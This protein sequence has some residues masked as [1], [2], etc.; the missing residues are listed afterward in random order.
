MKDGD[1]K[2]T[3]MK[4][5]MPLDVYP[6]KGT[7]VIVDEIQN[8]MNSG[9]LR[10]KALRA[11]LR[12][13]RLK[14]G[15]TWGATGT[16]MHNQPMELCNVLKVLDLFNEAFGNWAKFIQL[17]GGAQEEKNFGGRPKKIWNWNVPTKPRNDAEKRKLDEIV[18]CMRRVS[19][20]REMDKVGIEVPPIVIQDIIVDIDAKTKRQCDKAKK[21]LEKAGVSLDEAID[22]MIEI[23]DDGVGFTELSRA[24]QQLSVA[25]V[26][27]A[28]QIVE[29]LQHN[30]ESPLVFSAHRAPIDIFD[31]RDGWATITGSTNN[32]ERTRIVDDFQNGKLSGVACTI[33][34]GGVGITLTKAAY[35]VFVDLHWSPANNEQAIF[36]IRRIGQTRHQ[37]VY[38]IIANHELDRRKAHRLDI[39]EAMIEHYISATTI[40][41]KPESQVAA[42]A[43][44]LGANVEVAEPKIKTLGIRRAAKT[45]QERWAAAGLRKLSALDPDGA[46]VANEAGFN[47]IDSVKGKSLKSRLGIGLTQREWDF[48]LKILKKYHRQIGECP[49]V[50]TS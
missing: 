19:L 44:I 37:F 35:A 28:M 49:E 17:M 7:S 31:A 21:E 10:H 25:K 4:V 33:K 32:E 5:M 45:P 27:G 46:A 16:P 3:A 23:G 34:A 40:V 50:E 2:T 41:G 24:Y 47:K 29:D 6:A 15:T 12:A 43:L 39:K 14:D 11:I 18:A 8:A 20:R 36:R 1:G 13:V 38:R 48:A 42:E 30:G 9:A 26:P 22:R